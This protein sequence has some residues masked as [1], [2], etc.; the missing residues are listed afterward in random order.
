MT[1]KHLILGS[2]G[3]RGISILGCY[4]QLIKEKVIDTLMI[5]SYAGVSIGAILA[6]FLS[7]H[8]PVPDIVELFKSPPNPK[9]NFLQLFTAYG[10]DNGFAIMSYLGVALERR[11][12]SK[13]LTFEEHYQ[14]YGKELYIQSTNLNLMKAEIYSHKT[15]PKMKVLDAIRRSIAVPLYFVPAKCEESGHL[16]V[17]G[18]V[19]GHSELERC[20]PEEETLSIMIRTRPWARD[21]PFSNFQDYVQQLMMMLWIQGQGEE[22]PS[23]NRIV[24]DTDDWKDGNQQPF[25]RNDP[26]ILDHMFKL[27]ASSLHHNHHPTQESQDNSC[28]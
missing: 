27:G 17:D 25:A 14:H 26:E 4:D 5:K 10:V 11:G 9:V 3:N 1:I 28:Q 13:G 21:H 2:G 7:I 18:A 20:F 15:H 12:L 16:H 24:I 6:L 8:M 19:V 22:E 23:P